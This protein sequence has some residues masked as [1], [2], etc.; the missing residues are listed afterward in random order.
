MYSSLIE[1]IVPADSSNYAD[2]RTRNGN[3][4]RVCKIT[5]HHMSGKLTAQR[6]GELFQNPSRNASSNYGIGY[7]GE[8]YG[9]VDEENR[10]WTSSNWQNDIQ[11]IT[12]ECSNAGNN[13]SEMTEATWNSLIELCVDICQRY[14]F[15]LEYDGTPNGS[16]TKH[17]MFADTDCPRK[18]VTI[19]ATRTCTNCKSKIR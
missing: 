11:A 8:I 5:P 3:T 15:R 9:Y 17:N 10:A 2:G 1:K 6:C 18:L 13:T 7:N 14:D 12:I 16:L 19:K 4:Y